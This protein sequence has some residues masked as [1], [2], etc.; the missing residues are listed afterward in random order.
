MENKVIHISEVLK[1]M[2]HAVKNKETVSFKAWKIG[3]D[4]DDPE[5]GMAKT[6]DHVYVTSHSNTGT[7]NVLDPLA[8]DASMKY[9]H[10]NEAL[11][12]EFMGKDVIW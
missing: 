9:R 1:L 8:E 12:F 6:Y 4:A 7:Y 2:N 5:R 11:I 10:V 3:K